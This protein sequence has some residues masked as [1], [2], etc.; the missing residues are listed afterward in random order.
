MG[1]LV[2]IE[3]DFV[4]VYSCWLSKGMHLQNKI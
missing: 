2:G 3:V 4:Y 1:L